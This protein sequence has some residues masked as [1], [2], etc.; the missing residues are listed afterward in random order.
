MIKDLKYDFSASIVVFLVAL[1]LC[2]GVA[3][4]SGGT[5]IQG[6]MAGVI[7][8]VV[9][10][11]I[12][13]S[14]VSV[15]GPAAGLIVIV[16][17]AINDIKVFDPIHYFGVFALA[18]LIAGVFQLVFAVLKLGSIAD[19]IP[20]SVIKGMLAA[21]GIMLILK[22]FPHLLGYDRDAFGDDQFIQKDGHNTFSE[23]YYA[24]KSPTALALIIGL[25]GIILQLAYETKWLKEAKWK[26]F[27]PAP[28]LVVVSGILINNYALVYA[29]DWAIMSSHM[30][31]IPIFSNE[32]T[33]A[34][35]GLIQS[36]NFPNW[37]SISNFFVW[38]IA[39]LIAV[40]ASV[41]SLLSLEAGDKID[42]QK[43]SSDPNREL[44]AQGVGN[45][46]AGLVGALP[47]TAVIVRTSANVNSGSKTRASTIMHGFWL[48]LFVVFAP[49]LMNQIPLAALASVLIFIGYKLA[50]PALFKEQYQRGLNA[51]IPFVITIIAILLSDLLIGI[52]IGIVVGYIFVLR[53]N[54]VDAVSVVNEGNEYLVRFHSQTSFMNKATVKKRLSNIPS[55]GSV[56]FDFSNN[57][58]IDTDIIDMIGDFCEY[59]KRQQIAVEMKF[60]DEV[61][62]TSIL[63]RL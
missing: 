39:A 57:S 50:K 35:A 4:A 25:W 6:I 12:S 53:T 48:L 61:Q 52:V 27:I 58:F 55:K 54:Y 21:I 11:A 36:F 38:K 17:T 46:L 26:T 47:V 3:L 22:Q 15:S 23:I 45:I 24:I 49:K 16:E 13:G 20:V 18:V 19:F 44:L 14:H 1:P 2:M 51:I 10:G 63:G 31:D 43:R 42:H 40:I 33:G 41:E 59:A 62:K 7:G 60:Q 29:P 30:V 37:A 32:S 56:V 5:V 34:F 28:L 9:V 8:G